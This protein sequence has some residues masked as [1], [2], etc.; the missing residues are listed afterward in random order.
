MSLAYTGS[1]EGGYVLGSQVE[2]PHTKNI[3]SYGPGAINSRG[4]IPLQPQLNTPKGG[5]R[6]LRGHGQYEG[7]FCVGFPGRGVLPQESPQL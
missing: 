1:I 3:L 7:R 6:V 2:G 4:P 5:V